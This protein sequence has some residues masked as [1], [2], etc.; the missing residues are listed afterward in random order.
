MTLAWQHG[1][2][3]HSI[4]THYVTTERGPEGAPRYAVFVVRT[5]ARDGAG[6]VELLAEFRSKRMANAWARGRNERRKEKL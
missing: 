1:R 4:G 3:S 6:D 2:M 5:R